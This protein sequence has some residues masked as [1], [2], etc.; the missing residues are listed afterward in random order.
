MQLL[1][2]AE[3]ALLHTLYTANFMFS[4]YYPMAFAYYTY[5]RVFSLLITTPSGRPGSC[6]QIRELRPEG[7]AILLTRAACELSGSSRDQQLAQR[8]VGSGGLLVSGCREGRAP[9]LLS[10]CLSSTVITVYPFG[11]GHCTRCWLSTGE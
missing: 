4:F 7:L 6:W 8:P 5:L 2:L 10:L 3:E 11:A 1:L 9:S